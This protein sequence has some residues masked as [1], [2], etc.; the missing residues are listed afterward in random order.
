MALLCPTIR[1]ERKRPYLADAS[2]SDGPSSERLDVGT[3]TMRFVGNRALRKGTV[4]LPKFRPWPLSFWSWHSRT[5]KWAAADRRLVSPPD[6]G[7]FRRVG[8]MVSLLRGLQSSLEAP[9]VKPDLHVDVMG[10]RKGPTAA[11][12]SP[13]SMVTVSSSSSGRC[14]TVTLDISR[15]SESIVRNKFDCGAI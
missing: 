11:S 10:K 8:G 2:A 3:S 12:A 6:V 4:L 13:N 7:R 1:R 14:S 15:P 5:S 9:L